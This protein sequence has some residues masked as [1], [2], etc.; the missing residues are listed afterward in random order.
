MGWRPVVP[1][2]VDTPSGVILV[3]VLAP[4]LLVYTLPCE[5]R[6]MPR[7]VWPVVPR[8]VAL[9]CGLTIVTEL[10]RELAV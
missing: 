10:A 3:T 8:V 4:R 1:S 6:A 2:V 7:G 9:P 5:S